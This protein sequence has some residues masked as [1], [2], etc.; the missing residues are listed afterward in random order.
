MSVVSM[1]MLG[2]LGWPRW[3]ALVGHDC[4]LDCGAM[5]SVYHLYG[6]SGG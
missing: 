5:G 2:L 3:E 1:S 6:I 4:H